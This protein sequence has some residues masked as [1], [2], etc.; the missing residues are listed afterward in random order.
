[1]KPLPADSR[2]NAEMSQLI[3]QFRRTPTPTEEFELRPGM[4]IID[5]DGFRECLELEI[6]HGPVGHQGV[7]REDLE[8]FIRVSKREASRAQATSRG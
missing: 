6:S 8:D 2:W 3:E 5:W 1:M 7:L 4:T